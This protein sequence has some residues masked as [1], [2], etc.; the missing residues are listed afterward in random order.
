MEQAYSRYLKSSSHSSQS[1]TAAIV[2]VSESLLC[3]RLDVCSV[4]RA[5]AWRNAQAS[6]MSKGASETLKGVGKL[7]HA[8]PD[9]DGGAY[10]NDRPEFLSLP[11]DP[12][13]YERRLAAEIV[14]M[15]PT[16]R[17]NQMRVL[18]AVHEILN[19]EMQPLAT[20]KLQG[21]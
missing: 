3:D 19:I 16:P 2:I 18:K 7:P 17:E 8:N 6:A 12:R 20:D 10:D 13:D 1:V 14:G 5:A 9:R 21:I 4:S 15:M 11:G